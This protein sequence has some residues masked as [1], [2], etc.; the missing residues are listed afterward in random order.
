M[1]TSPRL[2]RLRPI[3][4]LVAAIAL[5]S[6]PRTSR[7]GPAEDLPTVKDE[8]SGG[9]DEVRDNPQLE[10]AMEAFNRGT[11]NYNNAKYTEALADF[12][13][14]ASLYASPDFQYNIGLCYQKL[15]KVDEAILAFETYLKTKPDAPDR[16]NVED[17]IARLKEAKATGMPMDDTPPPD[18]GPRPADPPPDDTKKKGDGKPLIIA[19]AVLAG[20]GA[21]LGLGG[22]IGAGVAA[23]QR[24]DD[25]DDIQSGGNPGN[26]S[27]QDAQDL[28]DEGKR[29][30]G[31]QI[32]LAAAG[33]A[34]AVTG[35]VLIAI[36][37]SKRKASK[38]AGVVPQLGP[39]LAGLSL[40]GRF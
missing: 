6:L 2:F 23:R 7:A 35:V 16:A 31:I 27:F 32:G 24:S 30:E 19:G 39:G 13:E 8:P 26:Q 17:R 21:A 15:G 10:R 34:I 37:L 33:A 28:E 20:V 36:G 9:S 11:E 12:Q 22:G 14:A 3:A 25:L 29:L 40:T 1:P 5:V 18:N 4:A 38:R